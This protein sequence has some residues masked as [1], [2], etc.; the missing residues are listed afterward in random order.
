[1]RESNRLQKAIFSR[2]EIENICKKKGLDGAIRIQ[3]GSY[4]T[5]LEILNDQNYLLKKKNSMW[6]QVPS[7]IKNKP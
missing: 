7:T 3:L 5:L 2:K 4:P 1:M 6:L